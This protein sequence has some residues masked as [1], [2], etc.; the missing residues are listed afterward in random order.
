M[1][2]TVLTGAL[3]L[4]ASAWIASDA[5]AADT[6]PGSAER[7]QQAYMRFMCYTCHGT[8]G[9]GGERGAGPKLTP[10]PFPYVAWAAQIRKPQQVMPPYTDR[11]VSEQDL[12]DMYAYILSIKPP[13]PAK[14]LPLP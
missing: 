10:N 12:A 9:Q 1:R 8:V 2:H 3:L 6:L 11:H 5:F 7:G 13:P 4:I 14:D